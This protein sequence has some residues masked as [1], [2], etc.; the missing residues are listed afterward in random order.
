MKSIFAR[1]LTLEG[2]RQTI[3][4]CYCS[5]GGGPSS[6]FLFLRSGTMTTG[7]SRWEGIQERR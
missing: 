4:L 3:I 1:K 2:R 7:R 6:L 5:V